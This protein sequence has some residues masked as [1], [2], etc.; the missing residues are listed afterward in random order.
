LLI[1]TTSAAAGRKI[2]FEEEIFYAE[3]KEHP[4]GVFNEI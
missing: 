1:D 4:S 2:S 3:L